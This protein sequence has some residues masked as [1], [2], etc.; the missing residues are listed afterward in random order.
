MLSLTAERRKTIIHMEKEAEDERQNYRENLR[1]SS[2][3]VIDKRKNF[4]HK[5][6]EQIRTEE[7][8]CTNAVEK[9]KHVMQLGQEWSVNDLAW[10]FDASILSLQA[11]KYFGN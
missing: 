5:F 6:L 9:V 8:K 7:E 11:T 1:M 2:Q 3:A 10:T 4:D